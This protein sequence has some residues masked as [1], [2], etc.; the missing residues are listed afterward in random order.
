MS[1][2]A[3]ASKRDWNHRSKWLWEKTDG[4][5]AYCGAQFDTSKGM[6]TDHLRPRSRGG[7]NSRANKFPCC[8]SCNATKGQRPLSYLRDALQRRATGRPAF[9]T[10]QV[11]YLTANGWQF[12][13][14]EP[15]RFYWEHL[16]NIFP[17][18]AAE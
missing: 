11:A 6:T 5:C 13:T 9:T 3:V 7:D 1:I 4:H 18:D 12:P 14:E 15:F 10:E 16:G 17:E 2:Q 8:V